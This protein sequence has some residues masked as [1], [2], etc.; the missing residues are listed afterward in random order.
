MD[1]ETGSH[2][3]DQINGDN[4]QVAIPT[5]IKDGITIKIKVGTILPIKDGVITTPIKD[6]E[7]IKEVGE[8]IKIKVGDNNSQIKGSDNNQTQTGGK[9]KIKDLGDNNSQTIIGDKTR[10]KDGTLAQ[11]QAGV[12]NLTQEPLGDQQ[13]L[14]IGTIHTEWVFHKSHSLVV[15][16]NVMVQG[17][18]QEEDVKFLVVNV[19][20]IMDFVSNVMEQELTL[21]ET[22]L[23]I[24]VMELDIKSINIINIINIKADQAAAV[25]TVIG[26]LFG[27]YFSC[28]SIYF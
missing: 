1:K 11:L 18:L 8:T 10:I 13:T 17:S 27:N 25:L 23:A 24:N 9:I 26:D 5:P 4:N 19:T 7:Q 15:A 21:W 28:L 12:T 14:T 2:I 16:G 6:L 20:D 22:N 3:K